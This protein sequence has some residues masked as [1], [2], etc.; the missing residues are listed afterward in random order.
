MF[1]RELV[2]VQM[3]VVIQVVVVVQ[4][5]VAVHSGSDIRFLDRRQTIGL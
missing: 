1:S 3:V 2:V 5:V 4:V